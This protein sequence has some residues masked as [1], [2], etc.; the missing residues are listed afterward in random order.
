MKMVAGAGSGVGGKAA[1]ALSAMRPKTVSDMDQG[2]FRGWLFIGVAIL[3]LLSVLS[4]P[5]L[6][7]VV[8]TAV[9]AAGLLV[10]GIWIE[11]RRPETAANERP[12]GT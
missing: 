8:L 9:A 3:A 10:L 11:L 1:I 2:R 12:A 6:F 4:W 5:D 7:Y